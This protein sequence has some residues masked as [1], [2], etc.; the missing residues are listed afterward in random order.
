VLTA[1]LA[2]AT[3]GRSVRPP[4]PFVRSD[5]DIQ[6]TL[7]TFLDYST[8]RYRLGG[9]EVDVATGFRMAPIPDPWPP[10]AEAEFYAAARA[11]KM[12]QGVIALLV[13]GR[14]TPGQ[15]QAMTQRLLDMG[16][17]PSVPCGD[18]KA[19]VR[20]I[21]VDHHIGL[22]CAGFVQQAFLSAMGLSRGQAHFRAALQED[23]SR[24]G[25][26]GFT[27]IRPPQARPGDIL[28]LGPLQSHD[29]GH[30]IIVY[31]CRAP[32]AA[33]LS[34]FRAVAAYRQLPTPGEHVTVLECL[35]S[36]GNMVNG[37]VVATHGGVQH[38]TL[39]HDADTDVW[40]TFKADSGQDASLGEPYGHEFQ[41]IFRWKH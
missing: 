19:F 31:A 39:F 29:V 28:C 40:G 10:R 38:A 24:L 6:D 16:C 14:A 35:S 23:L 22:D 34:L 17:Q 11:L 33:E 9:G 2:R 12:G 8:A 4:V 7:D 3:S 27:S 37:R 15:V 1:L 13:T 26:Q 41:G 32:T 20:Q 36:W 21:M 30:R 25:S 18:P 5:K